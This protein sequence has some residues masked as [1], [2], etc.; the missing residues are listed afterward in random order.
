MAKTANKGEWSEIYVMFKLLGEKRVYAGDG[1]LNKVEGL[2]YPI[3][4]IL[5]EEQ[6]GHYEYTLQDDIVVVTEDGH[7]LLRKNV[8]E[9]LDKAKMLIDIVRQSKGTFDI[10]DIE[11]F[12]SEINCSKIKAKSKD[13]TDIT[14][15]IHDL[16]TG[17][18]PQL[19]FSI[20][21]QVGSDSTLFNADIHTNFTY[22]V[23][24]HEFTDDEITNVNSIKT[25]NKIIDRV[26]AIQKLGG[27]FTFN[28]VDDI[29]CNNNLV[30]IDSCLPQILA[31]I[32]LEGYQGRG[33]V[34]KDLTQR[35][36]ERNP[37]NYNMEYGQKYYEHKMKNFLVSSALGMVP[38][39]PWNGKYDANGGYLVVKD[40]GEVLC[41]HFY[42]RNLFEDYL[43][44][45]TKLDS[46]SQSRHNFAKLYRGDDSNLYFKLN[47]QVRFR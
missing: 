40:D 36:V 2:F 9:F 30:L 34:I 44:C 43:F 33:K 18:T 23:T 15:V 13:K 21:S 14:I 45:N 19:G 24:G 42:D 27:R 37:L 32:L 12:M 20:K 1:N 16:R 17:M 35:I 3:L 29:I 25:R 31:E 28:K 10:P 41:Y 22:L 6:K 7:E 47:L 46:P 39:T 38:H 4:K 26:L 11:R 8:A 5:R